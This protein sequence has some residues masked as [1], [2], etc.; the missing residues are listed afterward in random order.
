MG[1]GRYPETRYLMT[2][3]EKRSGTYQLVSENKATFLRLV[4]GEA[5]YLEQI[6]P[7]E[8]QQAYLLKFDARTSK[9]NTAIA[10]SICEKWLLASVNC[11]WSSVDIGKDIGVWRHFEVQVH[12]DQFGDYLWYSKRPIKLALH[13]GNSKKISM[14]IMS[15]LKVFL[16]MIYSVM[17]IS[18]MNW[19]TGFFLP[20][21]T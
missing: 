19:I 8:P 4:A 11:V 6:I 7:V 2:G 12:I 10:I 18:P 21:I 9:P 13:N 5:I 16:V 20:T 3:A 14:L 17:E 15:G 1:L